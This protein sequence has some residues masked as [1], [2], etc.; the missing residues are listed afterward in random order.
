MQVPMYGEHLLLPCQTPKPGPQAVPIMHDTNSSGQ[1]LLLHFAS[2]RTS[3]SAYYPVT[4]TYT[5]VLA[6]YSWTAHRRAL[7]ST[8]S[9]ALHQLT[10]P[11][12]HHW[13]PHAHRRQ[14]LTQLAF[15]RERPSPRVDVERL[16]PKVFGR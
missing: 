13:W 5:H 12:T 4:A 9:T 11:G 16:P 6:N 8:T 2:T 15:F 1:R 3:M 7:F 10:L 14:E